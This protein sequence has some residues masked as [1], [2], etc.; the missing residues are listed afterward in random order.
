MIPKRIFMVWLGNAVPAYALAA[1]SLFRKEYPGYDVDFIRYRVSEIR[2][3]LA[4]AVR[5]DIDR[6]L[7][8]AI[9]EIQAPCA[10]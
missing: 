5:S 6:V 10:F 2:N 4:G 1:V 3:V 9:R 8:G 7:F